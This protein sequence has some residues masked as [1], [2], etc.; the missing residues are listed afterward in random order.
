MRKPRRDTV[1]RLYKEGLLQVF[2]CGDQKLDSDLIR[3]LKKDVHIAGRGPG[4][5]VSREGVLEVYCESGIPNASD[6]WQ[7]PHG[8]VHNDESWWKVTDWVNL[9]LKSLGYS[10]SVH[11]EPFNG[12]V[13]GIYWS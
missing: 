9:G 8:W 5:W 11:H 4:E 2:G 6:C 7:T 10:H 12:G 1:R 3:S 13:V